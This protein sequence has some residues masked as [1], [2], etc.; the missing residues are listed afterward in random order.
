MRHFSNMDYLNM[1]INFPFEHMSL[2]CCFL[3]MLS[4]LTVITS[5]SATDLSSRMVVTFKTAKDNK[6]DGVDLGETIVVKQY[7]RRLV[8]DLGRPIMLDIDR[9]IITTKI[10]AAQTIEN[11]EIDYLVSLQQEPYNENQSITNDTQFILETNSTDSTV[12]G[13]YISPATQTPLWNL[14]DSEPHSIHTEAVWQITNSTPDV[15]VAVVDTG[16]ATQAKDSFINLLDGYDFISDS[17]ISIDGDA[18]DPDATDPGDWGEECPVPSWHG[19]KVSSIIAAK[20]DNEFGMKGVAQNCSVLPIRVLGLCRMGYATDV[21]DSIV[22][23]AG[24][25]IIGVHTNPNPAKIISLSLAGQGRCPGYLQSAVNQALSLGAVVITAAGNNNKNVSGFFPA[26]CEGVIS[27]AASTRSGK[28]AEYSNWGDIILLSAPGGDPFDAIMTLSVDELEISTD[29]S[30]GMGTS[31]AVPHVAGVGALYYS[32]NDRAADVAFL[33]ILPVSWRQLTFHLREFDVSSNECTLLK[34]CGRGIIAVEVFNTSTATNFEAPTNLINKTQY[35]QGLADFTSLN[36]SI[37]SDAIVTCTPGKYSSDGITCLSCSLGTYSNTSGASNCTKCSETSYNTAIGSTTCKTCIDGKYSNVLKTE[38]TDT[39][40]WNAS[41]FLSITPSTQTA[42]SLGQGGKTASSSWVL[43]GNGIGIAYS[44]PWNCYTVTCTP[45]STDGIWY[46]CSGIN[47]P[48]TGERFL[49]SIWGSNSLSYITFTSGV[50]NAF[51][52][53]KIASTLGFISFEI[54]C[55]TASCTSSMQFGVDSNKNGNIDVGTVAEKGCGMTI[56]SR[57]GNIF[58]ADGTTTAFAAG[59]LGDGTTW[60]K[61]RILLDIQTGKM[62]VDYKS[63]YTSVNVNNPMW[64]PQI[65]NVNAK[66]NWGATNAQNPSLW[67]GVMFNSCKEGVHVPW[68][69]FTTYPEVGTVF[70][71]VSLEIY[72]CAAGTYWVNSSYCQICQ[73]GSFTSDSG[74]SA[75][76]LCDYGTYTPIQGSTVCE[77]CETGFYSNVVGSTTCFSCTVGTYSSEISSSVCSECPAGLYTA[78]NES[79]MCTKCSDVSYT[80]T[81]GS[82]AC[83]QCP[84]GM[85]SMTSVQTSCKPNIFIWNA[86]SYPNIIPDS[87]TAISLSQGVR[88]NSNSWF[89]TGNGVGIAYSSGWLCYGAACSQTSVNGI[90]YLCS[91]I[92]NPATYE[93]FLQSIWSQNSISYI[94]F[95][96]GVNNA[97]YF[98]SIVST[99]GFVAFE[100]MCGTATCASTIL[101]G[102]DS[103]KNGNIDAGIVAEKGCGMT[104]G[105]R[106]GTVYAADGTTAAF[107]AGTLGDGTTWYRTRLLLDIQTGKMRVDYKSLY[108]SVDVNNPQWIPQI[109]KVNA[110]FNWGATNAQNPSLWNGVMFTSCKES[111]HVPWFIFTVYPEVGTVFN[112]V[113]LEIE[114][115]AIGT[116]WVNSSNCQNCPIGTYSNEISVSACNACTAGK[117]TSEVSATICVSCTPGNYVSSAQSTT[118][119]SCVAGSYTPSIEAVN[120]VQCSKGKYTDIVGASEC[121]ACKKGTYTSTDS[122]TTCLNCQAGTYSQYEGVSTCLLCSN[123]SYTPTTGASVCIKCD[124]CLMDGHYMTGCKGTAPSSCE[125]CVNTIN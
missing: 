16:I 79:S 78:N 94:T 56:G 64:I 63:I 17:A 104:I 101:F 23:A 106:S 3:I 67:N 103:N 25:T 42:V 99:L 43:A 2:L 107:A 84:A 40:I 61:T 41:D 14:K 121:S 98:P 117:Y 34:I 19:T 92:N 28:I 68:F 38:C 9:E 123:A 116:Y 96:S 11:F 26:N 10:K 90:W 73:F 118:C 59:T 33:S 58:A 70:N 7:G 102:V 6:L 45:T 29:V 47:N 83:F 120:C 125:K 18:R 114:E 15:V 111:L 77:T 32:N 22:W 46:L 87:R 30:Y 89:L 72:A 49:Q 31:F 82:T 85:Y 37:V 108:T 88:S 115:C 51:Y 39:F 100:V 48:A 66:F 75:C 113:S 60:Y 54:L 91:G 55:A 50:T 97:F 24:G 27:V 110:K 105:S 76:T 8:L 122:A 86:S 81:T 35:Q 5:E 4:M 20:H 65:S 80:E 12:D 112:S 119:K 95:T 93:T 57:S 13:A 1:G 36:N 71:S 53:P 69:I 62:R 124:L 109:S 21:T 44:S 52:F 74:L